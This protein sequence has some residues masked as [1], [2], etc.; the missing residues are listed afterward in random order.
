[1]QK[2]GFLTTRLISAWSC[3]TFGA[4]TD[5]KNI[6]AEDLN[7]KLQKFYLAATPKEVEHRKKNMPELQA[8][9]YRKNT[10]KN[11]R[12]AINRHL[13]DIGRPFDIAK[14]KEFSTANKCLDGKILHNRRQGAYVP[15]QHK[16]ICA[17]D[18]LKIHIYLGTKTHPVILRYKVWFDL[19]FHFNPKTL[20]F[21][22]HLNLKSFEFLKDDKG[23]EH[24]ILTDET[25]QEI[26]KALLSE[27]ASMN[28]VLY[29]TGSETCPVKSLKLLIEK[30]P[31]ECGSLFNNC[32]DEALKNPDSQQYW[33]RDRAIKSY[34]FVKFMSKICENAKCSQLYTTQ[35]LR[36]TAAKAM[37]GGLQIGR[38]E[39][40]IGTVMLSQS[41]QPVLLP[42]PQ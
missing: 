40:T 9:E 23:V 19:S 17:A 21:H 35:C 34:Q 42:K 18:L 41:K 30:T 33:Y 32:S 3:E 27:E 24:A 4:D 6:E 2:A 8:S 11:V 20:A 38:V 39:A 37:N 14:D 13:K 16:E 7:R 31:P 36:A 5:F 28:R 15:V 1:M 12:A 25:R 26:R 29:A 22:Q 10:L